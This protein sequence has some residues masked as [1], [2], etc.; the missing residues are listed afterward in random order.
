MK[1]TISIYDF[2]KEFEDFNRYDKFS[3]DGYEAL[4]D[5]LEDVNE[6]YEIDVI[7]L[8]CDFEEFQN[9]EEYK[10]EYKNED[11]SSIEE[12]EKYTI[13]IKIDDESFI[14]QNY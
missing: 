8:C 13:V 3:Y 4:F 5:Y 2:R 12:L 7:E 9:F 11:I 14:I 10:S 1:K 6:D